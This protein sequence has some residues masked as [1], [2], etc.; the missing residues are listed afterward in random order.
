[1]DHAVSDGGGIRGQA[2]EVVGT[3][4]PTLTSPEWLLRELER[5]T[6]SW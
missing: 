6:V 1:M 5:M 4:Q 2:F 3:L